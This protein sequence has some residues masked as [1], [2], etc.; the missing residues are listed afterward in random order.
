MLC[1]GLNLGCQRHNP[2]AMSE[3]QIMKEGDIRLKVIYNLWLIDNGN[4]FIHIVV[5]GNSAVVYLGVV[6]KYTFY[7]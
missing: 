7:V 6:T 4:S 2:G 1:Q 5:A 3:I